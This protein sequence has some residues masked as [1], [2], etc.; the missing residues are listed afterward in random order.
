MSLDYLTTFISNSWRAGADSVASHETPGIPQVLSQ[1]STYLSSHCPLCFGGSNWQ[2]HRDPNT[3]VDCIVC[4]DACFTQK[5][6]NNPRNGIMQ[7]PPNP[8]A[9]VF[10]PERDVKVMEDHVNDCRGGGTGTRK[11]PRQPVEEVPDGYEDGMRI[12]VSV[13]DGCSESIVV[14]DEK[15]EKASTRFFADTGLM[16]LLCR[17]NRVLWLINMT[18]AGEKQYYSLAL[19]K[20]LFEHLPPNMLVRLLYD[21]GCQLE[22]SCRKWGLLDDSII[23][24]ISFGISVFHAYGHQWPCQIVYHPRKRVG[25]GLSDGEGCERLWSALKHLIPVLR[26][27]GYH[28]QLFVLDVQVRYLA[29]KSFDASG[30]WLARKWMLCQKKK[31]AA[32]DGLRDLRSDEDILREEWAAQVAHQTKPIARQSKHKG[33]EAIVGVLAL[34]KTLESHQNIVHELEHR[35]IS[36]NVDDITTFNLQL[37]DAHAR[38]A[39]VIETL[40]RRRAT[41][42]VSEYADLQKL[43]KNVYLQVCMN[44]HALKM[45]LRERL[46]QRKFELEKLERSY[47]NTVNELNMRNHTE[48]SIK[49]REPTILKIIST[50]NNLCDQLHVLIH[51]RK[52]PANAVPPIPISRDG[53][54]QLDVNDDIWQDVGLEDETADPPRWLANDNVHQG[55][56]LLLDLDRCLEEEDR[57]RRERCVMQEC[58]ILEWTALQEAQEVA[59]V[60]VAWH[61]QKHAAQLSLMCFEWQSRVRPIPTAWEM[62]DS[63]GPSSTDIAHAG[64]SLYHAKTAQAA[65]ADSWELSED[66]NND[67]DVD[68]GG[69]DDEL[70]AAVEEVAYA[71]EYR[72]VDSDSEVEDWDEVHVPSSPTLY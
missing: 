58:M 44:A 70:M 45:R 56:R 39:K 16:A 38:C 2:Q 57:L 27:S 49:R 21:I 6:S 1:P 67:D 24:R 48:A 61:L 28:Q 71:N 66:E 55:I 23:S 65:H 62:P 31:Q 42:G 47:R 5:C 63:W 37:H 46:R 43:K 15:R 32:L 41:L 54:F 8:T 18:S 30:Q 11:R 33:T 9:T 40:G 35:L 52:A 14:A 22:R 29:L 59:D 3:M 50:Y 68:E 7:D 64:H 60:D 12:P 10:I 53:I 20:R 17:H 4:I 26:V 13:L 19:V 36:N 51:Q 69:V 25:F 34:E 72:I